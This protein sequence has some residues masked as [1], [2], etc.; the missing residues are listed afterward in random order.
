MPQTA[1][2][3]K[4]MKR[5]VRGKPRDFFISTPPGMENLCVDEL[6]EIGRAHV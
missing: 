1:A 4:R 2:I 6:Q 3:E 5:H